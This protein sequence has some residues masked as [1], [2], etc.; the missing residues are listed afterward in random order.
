MFQKTTSLPEADMNQPLLSNALAKQPSYKTDQGQGSTDTNTDFEKKQAQ[1]VFSDLNIMSIST[2]V[3]TANTGELP[4]AQIPGDENPFAFAIHSPAAMN[5]EKRLSNDGMA[6][7]PV[8]SSRPN[9]NDIE[10]LEN[11]IVV[12]E[13]QISKIKCKHSQV[14]DNCSNASMKQSQA[15]QIQSKF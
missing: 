1:L 12:L 9:Q 6:L 5:L 3:G 14:V 13:K 8:E 10:L 11:K 7:T 2:S 15:D 4:S